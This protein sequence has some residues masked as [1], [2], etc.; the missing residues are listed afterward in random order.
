MSDKGNKSSCN[1][2][3]PA[4]A[5]TKGNR[6]AENIK[7]EAKNAAF[8]ELESRIAKMEAAYERMR[9]EINREQAAEKMHRTTLAVAVLEKRLTRAEAAVKVRAEFE[10]I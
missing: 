5:E 3:Q 6:E 4:N 9:V 8:A 7:N 1:I 2:N 10:K